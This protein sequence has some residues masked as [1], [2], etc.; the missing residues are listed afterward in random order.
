M[1]VE[2][3]RV[4]AELDTMKESVA[5]SAALQT[6]E[7]RMEADQ[8]YRSCSS[9]ASTSTASYVLGAKP[10]TAGPAGP[11]SQKKGG[12]KVAKTPR[13]PKHDAADH[14]H[15]L[16]ETEEPA[17]MQ[18]MEAVRQAE[19]APRAQRPTQT[20]WRPAR[21]TTR[22]ANTGARAEEVDDA[23]EHGAV[24]GFLCGVLLTICCMFIFL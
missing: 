10:E 23:F 22:P 6:Q 19:P 14:S 24:G 16:V 9:L 18:P 20:T 15:P 2:T 4:P 13:A 7:T 1:Y 21:R 8:D 11:T 12:K 17:S 3:T 5:S